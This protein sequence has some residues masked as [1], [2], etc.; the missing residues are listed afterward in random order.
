MLL[1]DGLA[2]VGPSSPGELGELGASFAREGLTVTAIGFGAGYNED[3]MTQLAAR[4]DG[5]HAFI[6]RPSELAALFRDELGMMMAVVAQKVTIDIPCDPG[7]KPVRVLGRPG[8]IAGQKVSL[9][10]SQLY[11]GEEK[12]VLLEIEVPATSAELHATSPGSRSATK[13]FKPRR[14]TLRAPFQPASRTP[15]RKSKGPSTRK[16]GGHGHPNRQF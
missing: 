4:S 1:S 14:Q 2:N 13:T 6:E 5:R 9:D 15:R 11:A 10:L 8:V 3:L 16:H 12:Y 7:V